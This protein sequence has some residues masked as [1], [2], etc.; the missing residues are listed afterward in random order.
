MPNFE[1]PLIDSFKFSRIEPQKLILKNSSFYVLKR[2]IREKFPLIFRGSTS[3]RLSSG[4]S[5]RSLLGFGK[6]F[7]TPF[8]PIKMKLN[9]YLNEFFKDILFKL[10]FKLQEEQ[11][12]SDTSS[13]EPWKWKFDFL[14]KYCSLL[15]T[16]VKIDF[17]PM[18]YLDRLINSK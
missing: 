3:L 15:I 7:F 6:Q 10:G 9:L 18:I 16:K 11:F 17:L 1:E 5:T 2:K 4:R 13:I 8:G 14:Y 12:I